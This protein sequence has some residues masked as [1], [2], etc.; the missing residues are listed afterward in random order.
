MKGKVRNAIIIAAGVLILTV[1]LT[2]VLYYYN[3]KV[4]RDN[5]WVFSV[6]E[7]SYDESSYSYVQKPDLNSADLETLMQIKGVGRKTAPDIINYREKHGK[8]TSMS[9]LK[10]I[11]SVDDEVYMI[12][13]SRFTVT[14]SG[15]YTKNESYGTRKVNL[16]TATVNELMSVEGITE[17][18]AKNIILRRKDHGDYTSVRELLDT[19]GITITLY[20]KISDKLTV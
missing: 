16:N 3:D 9:Q 10:E 8:F 1:M 6:D 5:A 12:L 4:M 20:S 7:T 2:V 11:S 14:S 19:D 15:Y 13:C 17:E 18:I